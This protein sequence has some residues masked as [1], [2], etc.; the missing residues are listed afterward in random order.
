MFK[1]AKMGRVRL[2]IHKMYTERVLSALQDIGVMQIES[3][4][5]EAQK[6]LISAEPIDYK[7]IAESAQ[8]FRGLEGLLYPHGS[9]Q[10]FSFHS[11]EELMGAAQ[12]VAIDERVTAIRKELD[13]IDANLKDY[14]GRL[15]LLSKISDFD[16]ELSVFNT[17]SIVSFVVYGPGLKQFEDSVGKRSK[18]MLST[19]LGNATIFSMRKIDEKEFG[20]AAEKQRVAI[21]FMP[22]MQG[23]VEQNTSALGDNVAGMNERKTA[24]EHEL[25]SISEKYYPLVSALKEQFDIEMEKYEVANRLGATKA[26][27]VLEGWVPNESTPALEKL[28]MGITE[29]R[30]ILE[31]VE[32][33]AMPPTKMRNPVTTKLFEFFVKF[34]SIPK[35]NEIDPTVMFALAFPIFFGFMVGDFGY[36]LFML[37]LALFIINRI[38]HPPKVSRLPKVITSFVMLLVSKRSLKILAKSIIPGAIIAMVL[39]VLFNEYFG[40]QLPYTTPFDVEQNLGQ[41]LVISG[42]I[43]VFMVEFGFILGALN[44]LAEGEKKHAIAKIGWVLAGLGFVLFGLNVLHRASLGMDNVSAILSYI[45]LGCGVVTIVA[46]EGG[47]G[48][49]EL[50][51]L[52][53]HMLSYTRL[54]GI[55]LAS[56]ILASV[57]DLVFLHSWNHSILLGVVGTV[58]L[59]VG[60]LFNI[61]IA[62]FEP[63]IQG[64][65]LIYVEFFSKFYE[66]N[67]REFKPFAVQRNRTLARFKLE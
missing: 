32:C 26:I 11:V 45:L 52:I 30:Y 23:S 13:R 59:I 21:E 29:G 15:G 1:P 38:N 16:G 35:S 18:E 27:V 42:Y 50:P 55:L 61:V 5:E 34:Y 67:G 12:S 3:L 65:R 33:E 6:L 64:A 54:V 51:S 56:V 36:G 19:K 43:G 63:G 24:L 17:R 7:Q 40:F 8:R 2:I 49:M 39:G 31:S 57:V 20:S 4:P 22:Q 62:L 47:R 37:L 46:C 44:K 25:M 14:H 9:D 48:I 60:Q 53:S 58:I 28:I 41:L 66:G 10:R